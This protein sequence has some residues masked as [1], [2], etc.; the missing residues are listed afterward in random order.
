[1][2][3]G[4]YGGTFDPI[5]VGHTH[6][7]LAVKRELQLDQV[8][9]VLAARPGHRG[10]PGSDEKHR[11]EMLRLACAEHSG[12]VADD[13]ELVR[14]GESYT[15]ATVEAVRRAHA[16][17]VPC[18]ILGQD[19]F[20]TLPIWHRWQELLDY[21]NLIVVVRPGDIREEPKA[22]Q[23]L[24][25]EHETAHFDDSRTGQIWRLAL[26]MREVSA[27]RIRAKL[28]PNGDVEDLLAA[29]VYTYIRQHQLY[30][31]LEH[32]TENPI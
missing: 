19:A 5:H 30:L 3:V 32:K 13:I 8:R 15:V 10:A 7:A 12:L 16:D 18:W 28:A 25:A 4:L 14:S 9:M 26:P 24:C 21:C 20:A 6:A 27:T 23:R 29:P 2:L 11:W 31:N 17:N 1:M 22:V